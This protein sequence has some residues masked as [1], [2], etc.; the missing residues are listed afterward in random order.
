MMFTGFKKTNK[1]LALCFI[2]LV[3]LYFDITAPQ[4][5]CWVKVL[6]SV[7]C[8]IKI[9]LVHINKLFI[10]IGEM[11]MDLYDTND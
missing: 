8:T 6:A 9:C 10:L 5:K 1:P 3:V 7:F 11:L 2:N 4:T